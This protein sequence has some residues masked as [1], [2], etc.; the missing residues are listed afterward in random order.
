MGFKSVRLF[1]FRNIKDTEINFTDKDIYLV[2]ENGQGKTNFL[3]S[4]YLLCYGS[5]FRTKNESMF[6]KYPEK[7]MSLSAVFNDGEQDRAILLKFDKGKKA[8]S[9][10]GKKIRD[11]KQL[12]EDFPC[13]AFT[14][15]DI[16]FVNGPPN[17]RRVFLNQT[18]SLYDGSYIDNL[19]VYNRVVKLRNRV[20]KERR[21]DLLDIYDAQVIEAGIELQKKRTALVEEFNT[22]FTRLY[23][24]ISGT[25]VKLEI[26]YSPSWKCEPK[27][28]DV[29]EILH[30]NR[31]RDLQYAAS[32]TGPHRDRIGF[33]AGGRN[34]AS[35]A[36][37][38]QIRLISLSLKAS[39]TSFAAKKS[40]KLPVLLLDDVLL[41][42]DLEKRKR[43]LEHLPDYR[44][45]FFTFLPDEGLVDYKEAGPLYMVND[46]II[47]RRY[48]GEI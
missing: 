28:A 43:F 11:R 9:I 36:S 16:N 3:E 44:Q 37:T 40:G 17:S 38:G 26:R 45:A 33:Y 27:V 30:S 2:G 5:S 31:G 13:I 24:I 34:Y 19:R 35:T 20:L 1:Q 41:E 25:S 8:I 6:I 32:T 29:S 39:Q 10:D 7:Q 18:I 48:Q 22:T 42:M 23:Q 21:I 4:I 47:S 12:L 14:H 15:D 46:G